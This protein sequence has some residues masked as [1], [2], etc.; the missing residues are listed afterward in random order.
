MEIHECPVCGSKDCFL[1]KKGNAVGLYC[2]DC[3]KWI[4]WVGKKEVGEF[5]HRGFKVFEEG[6]VPASTDK[7]AEKVVPV[8]A[9]TP[10]P[11]PT[12]NFSESDYSGFTYVEEENV[13]KAPNLVTPPV[14]RTV[15]ETCTLCISGNMDAINSTGKEVR[16]NIFEGILSIYR[17]IDNDILGAYKISYCPSCGKKI[18]G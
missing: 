13:R 14:S 9:P 3:G 8:P 10:K 4:K 6:Y 17:R 2:L 18:N 5:K 16:A 15:D 11:I 1:R 12:K 7:V